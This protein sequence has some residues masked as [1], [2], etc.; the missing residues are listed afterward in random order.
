MNL[1]LLGAPTIRDVVPAMVDASNIHSHLVA[2]PRDQLYDSNCTRLFKLL[3]LGL[4]TFQMRAC[5]MHD[6]E[7]LKQRRNCRADPAT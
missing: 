3:R 2:V 6:L 4:T 7:I 1:R 5:N